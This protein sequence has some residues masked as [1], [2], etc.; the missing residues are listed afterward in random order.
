MSGQIYLVQNNKQ[1]VEMTES[2]YD[3]EDLLQTL[4]AD[5]P[6]LLAGNQ[7]DS[8]DPRRWLLIRR[9]MALPSSEGGS[10]RWSVDHLFL[11][12]DGIPTIIE[13]K[14]GT[15]T[16]IR[17][18]VVGQMLEYAA[19][20][21][22]YWP[23]ESMQAQFEANCKQQNLDADQ[24]LDE[25]LGGSDP[26][27]FWQAVK[28]NLQAGKVRMVFVG[29]V[30]PPELRRIVEFLNVQ[31]SPAEVLAVEIKQ[32]TGQGQQALVPR[33]IG[34]TEQAVQK[35]ATPTTGRR[36]WDEESFFTKLSNEHGPA[37][38]STARR[39]LQWA[40]QNALTVGW[41]KGQIDGSFY[42]IFYHRG[43]KYWTV[44]VWT[45]GTVQLQFGMMKERPPFDDETRRLD[46][47]NR[48]NGL[49]DVAIPPSR[50]TT[51]PSISL[52]ALD[53]TAVLSEF[54]S[55]FD[56]VLQEIRQL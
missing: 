10:G 2:P 41:G 46:L 25:L 50:I 19:N 22:V 3:S 38:T 35:K 39:I 15:D 8:E 16:R 37:A 11:D 45:S 34:Q 6:N 52:T 48:L 31:M 49:P 36:Q 17:R 1:L 29:D 40:E 30:I 4:L 44:A 47:L 18:E 55:I 21:V 7:M 51:Y 24:H 14:R 26:N 42:P 5:Y 20:A 43:E 54:L 27:I 9:E 53:D 13:V 12:Q 33:V 28:T 56:S 23:V 32:Y